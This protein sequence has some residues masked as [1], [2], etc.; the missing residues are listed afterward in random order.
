MARSPTSPDHHIIA[1]SSADHRHHRPSGNGERISKARRLGQRGLI[2]NHRGVGGARHCPHSRC[3]PFEATRQLRMPLLYSTV[4]YRIAR[5]AMQN[6]EVI[7][8]TVPQWS[9]LPTY[10]A[11]RLE[12]GTVETNSISR[13]Q[14]SNSANESWHAKCG[15]V[16]L[17]FLFLVRILE[18]GTKIDRVVCFSAENDELDREL[19]IG[20]FR[21]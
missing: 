11:L 12:N 4:Q 17:N 15:P 13:T 14:L 7:G 21:W 16:G 6:S 1:R 18:A 10:N 19:W 9:S 5:Q 3:T 8:I 2:V 20:Q